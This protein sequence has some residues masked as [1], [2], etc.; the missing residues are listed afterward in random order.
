MELLVK[1]FRYHLVAQRYVSNHTAEGYMR[2]IDQFSHFL[3]RKNP[4]TSFAEVTLQHVKEFIK[5]LRTIVKVSPRTVSRKL[6]ALKT[7]STYLNTYHQIPLFTKGAIFPKL[8]KHLPK[9]LSEEGVQAILQA[10]NNDKTLIGQRNKVIV[11]LLYAC[12]MRV[13]ELTRLHIEHVNLR[14]GHLQVLGKGS[15]ERII[16]IPR[17]LIPVLEEY[18]QK[19]H[20]QLLAPS[21]S[22]SNKLFPIV[23]R[24]K[25]GYI[26]RQSVFIMIKSLAEKGGLVHRISPHMLRH[27]LATHLLKK[28]A[29]LRIL[30][31]L[32]GHEKLNTVQIYTHVDI[33]HL[34][35]LYDQYHPRA[36][37]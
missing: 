20:P 12:G 17:E 18:I 15:K 36:I 2:D 35:G 24:K 31:T 33:S 28:G 23:L 11:C 30:Q 26:T 37:K 14:E 25:I 8:P 21:K 9:H 19:I 34:R 3:A 7:F 16:P 10:A 32:L 1:K 29:N 5:Y 4:V 6:S 27:S 13:S 22:L